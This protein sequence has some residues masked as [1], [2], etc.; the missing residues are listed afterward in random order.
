MSVSSP[1]HRHQTSLEGV[2][3]AFASTSQLNP[4]QRDQAARIFNTIIEAS[5]PLQHSKGS[6]KQVT[7]V[8]LTYEYA[9]SEVSRDNFLR[10]FF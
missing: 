9:R 6:Y 4:E 7:L 10:F 8:R 5:E 3:N 1:H 2:I